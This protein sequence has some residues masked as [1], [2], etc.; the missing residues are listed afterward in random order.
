M[1]LAGASMLS[2]ANAADVYARGGGLK[3]APVDYGPAIGWSGFYIGA[4]AG[5]AF[6]N[7]DNRH[8]FEDRNGDIFI[9]DNSDD[10][11]FVGGGHVGYNWQREGGWVFGIE[12]DI[13]GVDSDIV[14]YLA[15]IRGRLGWAFGPSLLYATGGVA[16]AGL[17]N[18]VFDDDTATGYVVGAGLDYKLRE[19]W[20]VGV[21]GLYYNFEDNRDVFGFDDS[22]DFW[23]VRAR[24]TYHFADRYSEPLK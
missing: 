6:N 8:V 7:N 18:D 20:S 16:F 17:N 4:N 22:V 24:L 15:T 3:D 11:V 1:A 10:S 13:Q 23:S 19:N 12:G 9:I 14:D 21:E 5:A 2:T